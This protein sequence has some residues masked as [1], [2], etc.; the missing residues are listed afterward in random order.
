[1][2][3]NLLWE[4]QLPALEDGGEPDPSPSQPDSLDLLRTKAFLRT[5][6]GR[7]WILQGVRDIFDLAEVP[8][9]QGVNAA[10]VEPK[11]VL[12]GRGLGNGVEV[13]RRIEAGLKRG[14][15]AE[16]AQSQDEEGET[17]E[18]EDGSDSSNGMVDE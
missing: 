1:M 2:I 9:A 5:A 7:A 6:D 18:E 11:L 15:E 3:A 10:E 8:P 17:D 14:V 4:G 12:I 13:R 16:A